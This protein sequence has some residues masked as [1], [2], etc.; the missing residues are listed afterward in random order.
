[1]VVAT[2]K[3]RSD[4]PSFAQANL[5]S[6]TPLRPGITTSDG[7]SHS[8]PGSSHEPPASVLK[9]PII[10]FYSLSVAKNLVLR[11]KAGSSRTKI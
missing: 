11:F 4:Q 7:H 3:N 6:V 5:R 2:V 9:A 10:V 8:V 1:M